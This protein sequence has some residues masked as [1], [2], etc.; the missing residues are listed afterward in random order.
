MGGEGVA[1]VVDGDWTFQRATSRDEGVSDSATIPRATLG[2]TPQ[3]G[4]QEII[5]ASALGSSFPDVG[6]EVEEGIL[7]PPQRDIPGP[8]VLGDRG[9]EMDVGGID[10]RKRSRS[11]RWQISLTRRPQQVASLKM[12]RFWVEPWERRRRRFISR[13]TWSISFR[14][15]IL[16]RGMDH[17]LG[18][19]S[20]VPAGGL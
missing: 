12:M 1:T 7:V 11:R 19:M 5:G 3:G 18:M 9:R 20:I 2:S 15:R 4:D 13:M 17:S 14:V 16:E 10:P 6:L 8:V